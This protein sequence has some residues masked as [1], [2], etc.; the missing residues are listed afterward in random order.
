MK[1]PYN[2]QSRAGADEQ[3][4]KGDPRRRKLSY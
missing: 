1:R 3:L 2:S 4:K